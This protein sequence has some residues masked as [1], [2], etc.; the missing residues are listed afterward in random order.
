M[1]NYRLIAALLILFLAIFIVPGTFSVTSSAQPDRF[2]AV[3]NKLVTALNSGNSETIYSEFGDQVKM[4]FTPEK[5]S[6]YFKSLVAQNGKLVRLEP[7]QLTPPLQATFRA[8]FEKTEMEL[9]LYLDGQ[10]KI[11]GFGFSPVSAATSIPIPD[12][13]PTDPKPGGNRPLSAE[14][15]FKAGR[16]AEAETAF[17][18]IVSNNNQDYQAIVRLGQL[19]L[20]GNQF[21]AAQKWLTTAAN[22][23]PAEK[24][25][26][27]LLAEA[28]YRQ[29]NFSKAAMF[30]ASAG[31]DVKAK[32][33]GSFKRSV[34]Y[35]IEG[36]ADV[37]KLKFVQTDPLP[38]VQVRV[39]KSEPVYFL[40]D[41]GGGE[42]ILDTDY[43]KEAGAI[44]FGSEIGTF[45][46]NTQAETGLG[47]VDSLTLGGWTIRNLPIHTLNT[48]PFNVATSGQKV[49]GIIG[50]NLLYH[51]ISTIDYQNG[52]LVLQRKSSSARQ[53]AYKNKLAAIPFWLAGDHLIVAWGTVNGSRPMLMLVDTGLGGGGFVCP[54]STLDEME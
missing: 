7:P 44:L 5:A 27:S 30:F 25:P 24:T 36:R 35:R 6:A 33:I 16:F 45:G 18:N 34:P 49:S 1:R 53:D 19:A 17:S 54:Q 14:E 32:Q 29:D 40:I 26:F 9:K 10:D 11:L 37:V 13:K 46:A 48:K 4:A 12:T 15:L 51:F 8:H 23:K 52:E 31:R 2:T 41:T 50:T 3:A 28:A 21:D 38:L 39:N 20:L 42:T 22:L 43:A 47:K